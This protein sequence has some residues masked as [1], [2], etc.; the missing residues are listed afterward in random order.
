M[1][2]S[3]VRRRSPS[4]APVARGDD[5]AGRKADPDVHG[6]AAAAELLEPG[7]DRERGQRRAHRVIVVR[8]RPAEHREHGVAD[9]LLARA[10]EP[11]DRGRHRREGD[12]HARPDHLRVVLG[13]HPDVIDEVGEERGDDASVADPRSRSRLPGLAGSR[14]RRVGV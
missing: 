12:R 9:E 10:V 2:A 3:P 4:A 7:A 1:I 5:L 8:P 14:R 13:E 6:L 11:L